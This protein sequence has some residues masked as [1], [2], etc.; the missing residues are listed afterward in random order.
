MISTLPQSHTLRAIVGASALLAFFN[1]ASRLVGLLRDRVL[2]SHF[3]ASSILD[4]YYVSFS[5]PDFV[6]N[7]FVIGAIS[8]AF[9]PVFIEYQSSNSRDE[10][11]IANNFLNILLIVVVIAC[12]IIFLFTPSLIS[13]IAPG[14]SPDKKE[15]AVHFTRVML[16][17]PII[18]SISIVVSSLLQIFHRF[19]AYAL[20]PVLY[21]LGIIF[22]AIV[23]E[24]RMGSIGLAVG[25]VL[26]AILHLIVQ[27][28]SLFAAGYRW[29]R[30]A[31]WSDAGIR[32][33]FFLMVPRTI[34]LAA[35][36]VNM[37]VM[38]AIATVIGVGS[39]A[40]MNFANNLQYVLV[41]LVGISI[42]TAA[43]PTL[44]RNALQGD[45]KE[46]V[47]QVD[48]TL[49]YILILI[50]PLS[51]LCGL[52][53]RDVIHVVLGAGRFSSQDVATA[54]VMLTLFSWGIFALTVVPTLT[55]AFYAFQNTVIPL[56]TALVS[57]GLNI[58]LALIGVPFI[59]GLGYNPLYALPIAASIAAIVNALLLTWIFSLR[60]KEFPAARFGFF[61]LKVLCAAVVMVGAVKFG[62][63]FL[64]QAA[65][66]TMRVWGS[67]L[68][69]A[70]LGIGGLIVFVVISFVLKIQ[71]ARALL[72]LMTF[73]K[74]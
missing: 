45:K 64:N 49:R 72:R 16:V 66:D 31:D 48:T 17:S 59:R 21:N 33:I 2:A 19:F 1:L 61:F 18:F 58:T 32:K 14:F 20:A 37:M 26:G 50:I 23:L 8:S 28:P 63:S 41:S 27:L 56:V 6:F 40:I 10:W 55:R 35:M 15:L 43:F 4:V 5:I 36:Q 69:G 52:L 65:F 53:S 12:G 22:G 25:V 54:A 42:A 39:V 29:Q 24:P 47:S 67:I 57:V 68:H 71:E 9:I 73:R 11:H 60:M 38:G 44:S 7:L 46:F 51:I 74:I 62:D 30:V 70:I 13:L 34:G 3:G